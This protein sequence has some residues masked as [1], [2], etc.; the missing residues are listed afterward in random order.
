MKKKLFTFFI[1]ISVPLAVGAKSIF[2]PSF[3]EYTAM[4]RSINVFISEMNK[5]PD[6]YYRLHHFGFGV[7]KDDFGN[8]KLGTGIIYFT[9]TDCWGIMNQIWNS[10]DC[11][12]ISCDYSEIQMFPCS[13]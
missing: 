6:V 10:I 2:P 9:P 4:L 7:G 5:L 13:K 12:E 3:N 8:E 11:D 1:I